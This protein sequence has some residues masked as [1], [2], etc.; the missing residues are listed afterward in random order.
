MIINHSVKYAHQQFKRY[1]RTMSYVLCSVYYMYVQL[2]QG[3]YA[4]VIAAHRTSSATSISIINQCA[5]VNST[6]HMSTARSVVVMELHTPIYV[7]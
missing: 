5:S 3:R 6:V 2:L 7:S 4:V 1:M